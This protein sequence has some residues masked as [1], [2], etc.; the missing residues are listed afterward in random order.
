MT[1]ELKTACEVVFQEH[2]IA[3]EPINW[4]KDAFRGRLSFGMAALA[5]ETLERRNI[6][7]PRN[8]AKKTTTVLNPVAF[9]AAS[10]E[11]AGEIVQTRKT[12]AVLNKEN[13]NRQYVA[14]RFSS[15]NIP[16]DKVLPAK[17]KSITSL[18]SSETKWWMKPA[19]SYIVLPI[20]AAIVGGLIT[21][22]LG[23]LI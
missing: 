19:F 23:L 6:I 22:L 11:E 4:T 1:P 8:P 5:K 21:Y 2:K 7:C 9:E 13:S 10:F 3:A 20:C 18:T 14:H 16:N 12:V 15:V 17:T